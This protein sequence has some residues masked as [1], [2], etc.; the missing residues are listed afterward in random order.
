MQFSNNRNF[1]RGFIILASF[2]IVILIVWNTYFLF[3]TFKEEERAKME[4]WAE[5]MVTINNADVFFCKHISKQAGMFFKQW[6]VT[7]FTAAKNCNGFNGHKNILA[8]K[9]NHFCLSS[10]NYYGINN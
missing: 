7:G 8:A 9:G 5:S 2:L 4:L 3:Q 1:T 6:I 10:K